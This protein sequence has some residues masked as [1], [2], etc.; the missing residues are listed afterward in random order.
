MRAQEF[1]N[2]LADQPYKLQYAQHGAMKSVFGFE[3]DSGAEYVVHV[4]PMSL[5]N[6]FQNNLLDVSFALLEDGEAI[7]TA[8]GQAGAEALKVFGTVLEAVKASLAKRTEQ[9]LNIEYIRFT[10]KNMEPK[11]VALYTR[12]A[13]NIGRYLPG[14]SYDSTTQGTD[15]TS[16]I[17]KKDSR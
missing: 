5:G 10:A 13:R 7:D 11:R 14:W 3:T 12:M 2:E 16:F 4:H 15:S 6:S 17:V 8:T 9:G 1:L